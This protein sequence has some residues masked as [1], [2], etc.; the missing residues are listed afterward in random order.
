MN[1][2]SE[3][4]NC[5]IIITL[6]SFLLHF[7]VSLRKTERKTPEILHCQQNSHDLPGQRRPRIG[8]VPTIDSSTKVQ[9]PHA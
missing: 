2:N 3:K 9:S 4:N 8:L 5:Q 7:Q 6:T 1:I